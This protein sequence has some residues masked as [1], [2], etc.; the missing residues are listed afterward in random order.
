MPIYVADMKAAV[1]LVGV[2]FIACV[3][4]WRAYVERNTFPPIRA[5]VAQSAGNGGVKL[6]RQ[7]P[8]AALNTEQPARSL[9]VPTTP[10]RTLRN[11]NRLPAV[12]TEPSVNGRTGG[13]TPN[14]EPAVQEEELDVPLVPQPLARAAL[15]L[16]GMDEDAED[17]WFIA[18]NDPALSPEDRQDL[19]EDL[20]EDGFPDPKH[21]TPDDLPL[22]L[23]RLALIEAIAPDAMDEVNAAAFAEAYKDLVTM[24]ARLAQLQEEQQ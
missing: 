10:V 9:H 24:L 11:M 3:V 4:A 14:G 20:N 15:A 22:I 18:I 7:G 16:V 6:P 13:Q 21:I 23:S 5:A 17:L 19:I 8:D 1:I 2:F 12:K